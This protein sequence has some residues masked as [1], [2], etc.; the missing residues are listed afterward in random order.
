[1]AP[2]FDHLRDADVDE[3]DYDEAEIDY[4][5][6]REKYEVQLEKGYDT[7]VVID[8]LPIVDDQ[9]KPRLIKFLLRKITDVGTTKEDLVYMP[10]GSDGMSL[11]FVA[12]ALVGR[13]ACC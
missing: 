10:M 12:V 9:R 2:S 6:L 8:G 5:D 11:G 7:F 13:V 1:M 4:S 3:D